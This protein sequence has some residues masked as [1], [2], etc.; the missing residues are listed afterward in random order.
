MITLIKLGENLNYRTMELNKISLRTIICYNWKRGL[1][2]HQCLDEMKIL[3]G[4]NSVS[5]ST[6]TK[7]FHEFNRGCDSLED[8]TRSGR[9]C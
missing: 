1:L 6:E 2:Q 9:P 7:W 4:D 3:L 8:E 5:F